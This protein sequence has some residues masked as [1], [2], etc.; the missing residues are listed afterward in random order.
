MSK[1]HTVVEADFFLGLE[2]TVVDLD[3]GALGFVSPTWISVLGVGF[4]IFCDFSCPLELLQ[5]QKAVHLAAGF[6][7]LRADLYTLA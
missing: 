4:Y 7:A 5:H 3:S 6:A 1:K 2:T